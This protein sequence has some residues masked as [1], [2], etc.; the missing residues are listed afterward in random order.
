MSGLAIEAGRRSLLPSQGSPDLPS[1]IGSAVG[2]IEHV[3][4]ELEDAVASVVQRCAEVTRQENSAK[5]P[6]ACRPTSSVPLAERLLG[7]VD[8]LRRQVDVLRALDDSLGL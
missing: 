4:N 7:N 6:G 3:L 2:S 5:E 1:E 8:R